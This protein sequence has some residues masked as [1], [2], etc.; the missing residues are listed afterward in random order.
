MC[1]IT[2]LK[3]CV[4]HTSAS[5]RGRQRSPPWSR[6]PAPRVYLVR[7]AAPLISPSLGRLFPNGWCLHG[8][9]CGSNHGSLRAP[10]S[11]P[12]ATCDIGTL[13]AAGASF[14]LSGIKTQRSRLAK[15]SRDSRRG[16][17][18]S[19]SAPHG[20]TSVMEKVWPRPPAVR[21]TTVNKG[22]LKPP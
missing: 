5:R 15:P 18:V 17:G 11:S 21:F 16:N 1:F 3:G 4:S 12:F 22:P 13:L 9:A 7:P 20:A 19:S 14:L 2:L 10:P 8:D 6:D